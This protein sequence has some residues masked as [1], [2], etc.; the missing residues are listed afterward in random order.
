MIRD[1]QRLAQA[2]YFF[3][4]PRKSDPATTNSILDAT[5]FQIS[6]ESL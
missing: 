3:E 6:S 4:T 2:P 1:R 5:G